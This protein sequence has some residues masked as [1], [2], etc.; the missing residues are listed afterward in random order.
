MGH[1]LNMYF[2]N[3]VN[4][5]A[6]MYG[7]SILI[8]AVIGTPTGTDHTRTSKSTDCCP[9]CTRKYVQ[10]YINFSTSLFYFYM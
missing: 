6:A 7:N 9:N 4:D 1:I 8:T 2:S 10:S 3:K 5:I